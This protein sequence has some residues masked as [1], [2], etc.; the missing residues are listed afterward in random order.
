MGYIGY[1]QVESLIG[2]LPLLEGLL[3]SLH[4][5]LKAVVQIDAIEAEAVYNAAVGVRPYTDM[6]GTPYNVSDTTSKIAISYKTTL[7]GEKMCEKKKIRMDILLIDSVVEKI[8]I[9]RKKLTKRQSDILKSF[10][11]ELMTWNEISASCHIERRTAQLERERAIRK[12]AKIAHI[13]EDDYKYIME[14]LNEH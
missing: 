2:S 8:S 3:E 11:I 7:I 9:S 5:D 10:Y 1:K 14:M 12:V 4:V 6:P 13:T